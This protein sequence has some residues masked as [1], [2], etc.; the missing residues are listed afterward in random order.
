MNIAAGCTKPP[1][2]H[3]AEEEKCLHL[4]C[5]LTED[6][7]QYCHGLMSTAFNTVFAPLLA[8]T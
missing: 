3:L 2:P 8:A 7:V 6:N 4:L 5:L 1:P